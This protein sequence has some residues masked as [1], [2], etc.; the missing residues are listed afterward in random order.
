ME[1]FQSIEFGYNIREASSRGKL[2]IESRKKLSDRKIG[3][4][5][6]AL[7]KENNPNWAKFG[8]LSPLFKRK[9]PQEVCDKIGK[10]HKDK[11]IS[12]EV[13]LKLRLAN[14]G[15]KYS[16]YNR[17]LPSNETK[18]KIAKKLN[19][20]VVC[21]DTGQIFNSCKKAE[22]F[23]EVSHIGDVCNGRRS[24]AKGLKFKYL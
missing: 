3:V 11:K 8:S 16:S 18:E 12:E 2:N 15:K 1:K 10:K 20:K 9:R 21:I 17:A 13:K 5:V 14:L 22:E 6:P 24:S 19:K 7:Q 23:F 4:P